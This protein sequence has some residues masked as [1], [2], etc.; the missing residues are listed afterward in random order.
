MEMWIAVRDEP[1]ADDSYDHLPA[2]GGP[3]ETFE[4]AREWIG[5]DERFIAVERK[6]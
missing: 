4:A 2:V 1:D 3:F 6:S 5:Y